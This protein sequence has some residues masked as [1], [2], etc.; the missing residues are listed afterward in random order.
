M[1]GQYQAQFLTGKRCA[2]W[3]ARLCSVVHRL[4][5]DQPDTKNLMIDV[6][7]TVGIF[8][9]PPAFRASAATVLNLALVILLACHPS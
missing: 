8:L 1:R 6:R 7:Q 9:R 4:T 5:N 3:A 2:V